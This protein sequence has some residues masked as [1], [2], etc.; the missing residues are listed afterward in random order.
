MLNSKNALSQKYP[1]P[2]KRTLW[3]S[4][5]KIPKKN[6]P[7]KNS[8]KIEERL[9]RFSRSQ[10]GGGEEG[11]HIPTKWSLRSYTLAQ[12]SREMQRYGDIGRRAKGRKDASYLPIA[13]VCWRVWLVQFGSLVLWFRFL[14][15]IKNFFNFPNFFPNY[16]IFNAF[17]I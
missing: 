8:K 13:G 6:F 14:L 9:P 4:A 10:I 15:S 2:Q 11:A 16:L 17:Q 7:K 3:N 1:Q 12:A 5:K